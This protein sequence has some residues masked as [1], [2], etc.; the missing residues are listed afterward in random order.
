MAYNS[1]FADGPQPDIA[2]SRKSPLVADPRDPQRP[3]G[4]STPGKNFYSRP[5]LMTTDPRGQEHGVVCGPGSEQWTRGADDVLNKRSISVAQ[6]AGP[7]RRR[8]K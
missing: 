1:R 4:V 5:E 3:P 8:P 7:Q 2:A 6:A